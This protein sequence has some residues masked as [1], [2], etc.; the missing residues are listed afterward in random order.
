MTFQRQAPARSAVGVQR[1][2]RIILRHEAQY[3]W[4]G[5]GCPRWI[6]RYLSARR[7]LPNGLRASVTEHGLYPGGVILRVRIMGW[8]V[9]SS[10]L[11]RQNATVMA[12]ALESHRGMGSASAAD[13]RR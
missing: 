1:A 5:T 8:L 9:R 7:C 4:Q 12:L 11:R 3:R 2:I 13:M 6:S 10:C